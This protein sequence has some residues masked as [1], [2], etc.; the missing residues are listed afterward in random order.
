MLTFHCVPSH[1][2]FQAHNGVKTFLQYAVFIEQNYHLFMFIYK[3]LII[4][5]NSSIIFY[6]INAL[7]QPF[8]Y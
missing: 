1:A 2:L 7:I 4:F 5:L 8:S 6:C 3:D